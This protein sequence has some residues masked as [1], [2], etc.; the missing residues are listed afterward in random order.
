[1]ELWTRRNASPEWVAQ[2]NWPIIDSWDKNFTKSW[3]Y[4]GIAGPSVLCPVHK[5]CFEESITVSRKVGTDGRCLGAS[6][7]ELLGLV[8]T[9]RPYQLLE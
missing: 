8:V 6:D 7:L 1:M 4:D 3:A 9:A 5:T 2:K